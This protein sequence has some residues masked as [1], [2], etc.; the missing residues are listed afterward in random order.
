MESINMQMVEYEENV[1][2]VAKINTEL[3][4]RY[5]LEHELTE[6]SS[7]LIRALNQYKRFVPLMEDKQAF[8]RA[9]MDFSLVCIAFFEENKD[10]TKTRKEDMT[11]KMNNLVKTMDSIN[12][13][14][15]NSFQESV[16]DYLK[17]KE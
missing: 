3:C 7:N 16:K 12:D 14:I 1:N 17:W 2:V 9:I 6:F 4:K 8:V 5:G 11:L 10:E 15:N 13:I